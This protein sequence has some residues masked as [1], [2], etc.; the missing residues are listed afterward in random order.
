MPAFA[1]EPGSAS[2]IRFIIS[3][4]SAIGFDDQAMPRAGKVDNEMPDRELS[5]ESVATEPAVAQRQPEAPF[6]IRRRST[7]QA[8]AFVEPCACRPSPSQRC[9]LGPSLS[10]S[11]GEALLFAAAYTGLVPLTVTRLPERVWGQ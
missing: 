1:F 5:T 6:G 8:G 7:Q 11:A 2:A 10:R 4:L 3:M 9:A